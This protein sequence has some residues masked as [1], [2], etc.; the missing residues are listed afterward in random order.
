MAENEAASGER[1]QAPGTL[2]GLLVRPHPTTP[3][4]RFPHPNVTS[5]RPPAVY[6]LRLSAVELEALARRSP[7]CE[8]ERLRAFASGL[9]K[10]AE[11]NDEIRQAV[12]CGRPN[13][14]ARAQGKARPMRSKEAPRA[15]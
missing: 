4:A 3:P 1:R 15:R 10:W 9:R 8:A 5:C 12:P 6:F 14:N 11:D 7:A 2:R 13:S